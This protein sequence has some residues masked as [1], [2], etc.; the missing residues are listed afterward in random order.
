MRRLDLGSD[1]GFDLA[2]DLGFDLGFDHLLDVSPFP[3]VAS[4]KRRRTDAG[5]AASLSAFSKWR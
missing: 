3:F 1:L 5:L 4:R 2:S